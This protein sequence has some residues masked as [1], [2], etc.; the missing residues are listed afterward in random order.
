M[1]RNPSLSALARSFSPSAGTLP[2]AAATN[3][4]TTT[5]WSCSTSIPCC[6]FFCP[7][8]ERVARPFDETDCK[9]THFDSLHVRKSFK[10]EPKVL[11]TN[12]KKLQMALHPDKFSNSDPKEKEFSAA[13]S[14]RLNEAFA[15]LKSPVKRALYMLEE[16]G[17][18][19]LEEETTETDLEI[20]TETMRFREAIEDSE[21][22]QKGLEDLKAEVKELI[23]GAECELAS[24]IGDPNQIQF[25]T[26]TAVRMRYLEKVLDEID[27]RIREL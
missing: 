9:C 19:A 25:S 11:E 13:H 14:S 8:C 26:R 2:S 21:N 15:V 23:H 5:C 16:Q 24:A 20:L 22:D 6:S 27:E 12:Y 4:A 17:V 7:S 1:L 3:S 18:K 10:V